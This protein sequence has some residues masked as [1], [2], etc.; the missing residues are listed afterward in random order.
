MSE[1]IFRKAALDRM[2]SP[3]Q[4]DQTVR[5]TGP[6][7]WLAALGVAV[8]VLVGLAIS[9][10]SDAAVKVSGQGILIEPGGIL[11]VVSGAEGR[12]VRVKAGVGDRISAGDTVATMMQ[13]QLEQELISAQ[14]ELQETRD[15]RARILS[16]HQKDRELQAEVY[17]RKKASLEQRTTSLNR[18]IRWLREKQRNEK[19]LLERG[20]LRR[21]QYLD[22]L[23]EINDVQ[24]S[25]AE[26]AVEENQMD[27]DILDAETER[28]R[29]LLNLDL[30]IQTAERKVQTLLNDLERTSRVVSPYSGQVVE[31]KVN[32]G[33]I[34]SNG[35]ALFSILPK[36]QIDRPGSLLGILFVPP[37]DGKQ[38][39]PGMEVQIVPSTVKR[40]EYGY[41][42]GEVR[43]VAELPATTEGIMRVLKNQQLVT[44]LTGEGAPFEIQVALAQDSTTPSGY[45]WS[46]SE[47]PD[48]RL[49]GGTLFEG[50]VVV[51]HEPLISL[52]L[53]GIK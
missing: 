17:E 41:L 18:R 2:S 15:H 27:L 53:P 52:I 5:L 33:E 50:Q 13:P 40:E 46:S 49:A 37:G 25:L 12:V 44:Q 51:K 4:L 14:A 36:G 47:G 45:R 29:E 26:V 48:Q 34:L 23:N 39:T 21:Q 20:H 16:F 3:D 11:D 31:V 42:Q 43:A 32:V 19:T 8:F 6:T 10:I 35:Q 1:E 7:V 30:E 28:N 22:T 24:D 9:F 38:V